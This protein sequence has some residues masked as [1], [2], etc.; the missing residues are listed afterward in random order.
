VNG[1]QPPLGKASL[2]RQCVQ[3]RD[4]HT[5]PGV[6]INRFIIRLCSRQASPAGKRQTAQQLLRKPRRRDDERT[7]R[8]TAVGAAVGALGRAGARW[9]SLGFAWACHVLRVERPAIPTPPCTLTAWPHVLSPASCNPPSA[10]RLYSPPQITPRP[11]H[12]AGSTAEAGFIPLELCWPNLPFPSCSR[13]CISSFC[14]QGSPQAP[15]SSRHRFYPLA[16]KIGG[17]RSDL[18]GLENAR[19]RPACP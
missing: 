8:S 15:S 12:L 3:A 7:A 2:Y 10:N 9:G 18:R 14:L 4:Q 16:T 5:M 6:R 11:R 1:G 17:L 13:P 19:L